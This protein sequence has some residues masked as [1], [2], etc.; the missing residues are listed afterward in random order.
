MMGAANEIKKHFGDKIDVVEYKYTRKEDIAR[1]V[2]M[3]VAQ[4]P[5]IYISGELA[6]SSIIPSRTEFIEKVE[7]ACKSCT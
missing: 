5:S 1:F 6:C 7:A 4:L 2:K 3:G